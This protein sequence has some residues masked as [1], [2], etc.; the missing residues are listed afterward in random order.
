[1][2]LLYCDESNLEERAGDFL[3]Y[4]GL[5]VDAAR[6]RNLSIAI[7]QLRE[8]QGVP[9]DYRF[10]FNPG[11]AGLS[12]QQFLSLKQAALELATAHQVK[13]IIYVILHDI[14]TNPDTARR[15]GINTVCFHFNAI[16]NQLSSPGL[17][18]ID[19]FTDAGNEIDGHLRDKFSVGVT[20]LPYAGE[21]RL[22]NNVGFHYSAIGQSHFPS[23][24]DVALGSLRFALNAHTRGTTEHLATATALLRLL[25]PLF[26]RQ[27]SADLVPELGFQ[28]S[29]KVIRAK[30]YR[31]RYER[32]KQFLTDAGIPTAQSITDLRTY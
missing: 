13:L 8:A 7:D 21:M 3:I 27:R 9:R 30:H 17:V 19:R 5:M 29:P 11:P 10:K 24:L 32:L 12:H 23:I 18:L 15:N 2:Q 1:M 28:F 25:A 20:G 22:G 4:G 31:V 16:L 6:A 14:A 26:W